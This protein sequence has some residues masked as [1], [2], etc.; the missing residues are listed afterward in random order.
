MSRHFSTLGLAAALTLALPLLTQPAFA[1]TVKITFVQTNDIDRM[2]EDDGRGG[3][4]R[5]AAV[6]RAER[7]NGPTLFVHSGD[8]L[9]PSL[10]SGIDRGA[11]MIDLLNQMGVDAMVPGNHE[12]DFGADV[13]RTRIGEATFPV[14]ASNLEGQLP[15]NIVTDRIIE[16]EGIKVGL[17]GLT[18]EETVE[19]STPGDI[20][21]ANSVETGV[22]RAAA[23][24]E[25][26]ADIVVAVVHTPLAVDMALAQE[27][28]ADLILSG[29]DEH[30]LAFYD[31]R[32]VI[33]ESGS[34]AD[35]AVVTTI[36]VVKTEEDGRVQIDWTPEFRIIDTIGVTPDPE[37][38]ALVEAYSD[39]L[40]EE[41]KV[42][43]G[44]AETALDSRR[45]SVRS[46]ETAIGNLIADAMREAVGA[47]V[48]ITN[49]GG[50]RA[51]KEYPAGHRLTRGDI[52]AEL[53][54]GNKTV[55]LSLT[56]AQIR[57]ALENGLSQVESSG[58]RFPQISGMTVVAD[59]SQPAGSRVES[60][61]VG[62]QR[63]DDS[64]TY[65]L[66]TNDF[67]ANGG[68]GY[69]VFR[70]AEQLIDPIDATLMASQVIDYVAERG[71]V[72][73]KV[74]GRL[75]Q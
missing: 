16:I 24:R 53:P 70:E 74:E 46:G 60:V 10:L 55:K 1:Q 43:I 57:A 23:L 49:G 27:N 11:H 21:F 65:T 20:T 12:F 3:V 31:G 17:Y 72:A 59:V 58:G 71:T 14:I 68:D 26:G 38:A 18:T 73:P 63:L 7:A 61:T 19:I 30:L 45:A 44:I 2:E 51:D 66:A 41:L 5:L 9:S 54:F 33:T 32:N 39:K 62:G 15:R 36:T 34:Q 52:L 48:A 69:V 13:F 22:A 64:R 50:I 8:T 35:R 67:M 29:H 6:V 56:G 75:T 25:A 37:V 40:D 28:A 42:E 4:A 47:D